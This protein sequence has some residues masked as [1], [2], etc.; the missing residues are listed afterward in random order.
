MRTKESGCGS[1]GLPRL[2]PAMPRSGLALALAAAGVILALETPA[3]ASEPAPDYIRGLV[4]ELSLHNKKLGVDF[5]F[6]GTYDFAD[7]DLVLHYSNEN[8]PVGPADARYSFPDPS[9]KEKYLYTGLTNYNIINT[10]MFNGITNNGGT[11]GDFVRADFH[12]LDLENLYSTSVSGKILTSD[13]GRPVDI[14]VHG[15][16]VKF[17]SWGQGIYVARNDDG[18]THAVITGFGNLSILSE[19]E[20]GI[21]NNGGGVVLEGKTVSIV[22]NS[23]QQR[24]PALLNRHAASTKDGE[25]VTKKIEVTADAIEVRQTG[26][27]S[28]VTGTA[29][30]IV[31]NGK[32][33]VTLS[34]TDA[35]SVAPTVGTYTPPKDGSVGSYTTGHGGKISIISSGTI[36][37]TNERGGGFAIK[38][39]NGSG[40]VE[41]NAD[42][43]GSAAVKGGILAD[44]SGGDTNSVTVNLGSNGS[45]AGDTEAKG[46]GSTVTLTAGSGSAV[47]GDLASSGGATLA[48]T[49]AGGTLTGK[50]TAD[51]GTVDVST[52]GGGTWNMTDSSSVTTLALGDGTVN[53]PKAGS[54][55]TPK[56][57]TVTGDFTG[58]GGTVAIST[59][60]GGDDSPT[61]R[62]EIG[63]NSSGT[64]KIAVTNAGGTGAQTTEGIEVVTV[65]GNSDATFTK[66]SRIAAGAYDYDLVKKGK[67]WYLMSSLT[68]EKPDTPV[69]PVKPVVPNIAKNTVRPEVPAYTA[70]MAASNTLFLMTLHDR[71][72][73]P[74]YAV[75]SA[76]NGGSAWVRV[77]GSHGRFEMA[78]RQTVTRTDSGVGQAGGDFFRGYRKDLGEFR[79]GLMA[80][81]ADSTSKTH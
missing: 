24:R 17:H 67:N 20:E 59:A 10:D 57:L 68:P 37:I 21:A 47:T 44:S 49:I 72:G 43:S 18:K 34:N 36:S 60:L 75:D 76:K 3:L 2:K 22:S 65:A 52:A 32:R 14:T 11:V 12:S 29:G 63:G 80:G 13:N 54:T 74:Q 69:T 70:N 6:G 64:A 62:L 53:F 50:S 46:A 77:A 71:L 33:S 78:D 81:Y 55:F 45:L 30:E 66:A 31:L 35:N 48:A 51:G 5:T 79:L 27:S 19:T 58:N 16:D 25:T 73:N 39:A 1:R 4:P 26:A 23:A 15:G 38:A 41:V 61:D 8:S 28:A 56:T 42:G 7:R 9:D 40:T